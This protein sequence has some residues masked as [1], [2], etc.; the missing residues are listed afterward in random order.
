MLPAPSPNLLGHD[1]RW[2]HSAHFSIVKSV[3][4][5]A[6]IFNHLVFFGP[7][8]R[9]HFDHPFTPH[10]HI[11]S[12]T[13][14]VLMSSLILRHTPWHSAANQSLLPFLE[15][16]VPALSSC[17]CPSAVMHVAGNPSLPLIHAMQAN[18]EHRLPT[19]LLYPTSPCILGNDRYS[20]GRPTAQ[21]IL[22]R[23]NSIV[24]LVSHRIVYD[25][26]LVLCDPSHPFAIVEVDD[27][28]L[29]KH[30]DSLGLRGC[31]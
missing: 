20:Y 19:A 14:L 3:L 2:C 22:G 25:Q 16:D 13:S 18:P 12:T 15:M 5:V 4:S 11:L 28:L 27:S 23:Y 1:G 26:P 8:Y 10:Q 9:A 30:G 6:T 17:P 7:S 29:R 21:Y 24:A 31:E